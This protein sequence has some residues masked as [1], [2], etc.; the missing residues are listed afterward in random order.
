MAENKSSRTADFI[1]AGAGHNGLI[2]AA[3]LAR[4]GYSVIA[5]DARHIPGGGAATEEPLLPGYRIDSCST[6]HTIIQGNPL[7]TNDELGLK[8]DFR[9]A[10][11][12]PDPVAHVRFPDGEHFTQFLDLEKTLDEIARFSTNDAAA[13]RRMMLE[14]EE[15][16][17]IFGREQF[18]PA[19][20]GESVNRQLAELPSGNI[21]KR[22]RY[23]SAW[24]IIRHEFESKHI[25]SFM[26][27]QAYQ[28]LVRPDATGSG[29]LAYST[30]CARQ[31]R[32]WTIPIG[33]SGRLSEALV[34]SF[35]ANGGEVLINQKVAKLI[36]EEG[37]C[38]GVRTETGDE[39]Y[40]TKGVVSSIHVKHLI[41]MAPTEAWDEAWHYGVGTYDVGTSA[42]AVYLVTTRAPEFVVE[43]GYRTAVSA[44]FVGWPEEVLSSARDFADGVWRDDVQWLLIATPTL[45]DPDRVPVA[46]HHTVK[47]LGPA[48]WRV[49]AGD[50]W[51][52]MKAR[53]RR[54]LLDTVQRWAPEFTDDAVLASLVKGPFDI[55]ASN[56]HMIRG[57]LH[58]G[59]RTL[60]FTGEQ[61]PAPGWANHLTPRKGLYQTGAT[62]HPGGSITGGPGRNAALVILREEGR[63]LAD[64]V[65]SPVGVALRA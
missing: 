11:V 64:V 58:G 14:W 46:G 59:E 49:P 8:A 42:F 19:G 53:R 7:M 21:W 9:L 2:T 13:F 41:D 20:S 25:Q 18:A 38:V 16:K 28:T 47:L 30:V 22:R 1:V 29:L 10:Y 63:D 32:S 27:W 52:S 55:E 57:T 24:D 6:G 45:V 34:A 61:R 33:G 26:L 23:L 36:L 40:G 15:V 39:F 5:L 50:D 44:G 56:P 43:G 37:R 12:D 60:A 4:A 17:A 31:R 35:E 54:L 65:A 62:T 3:Y 48:G 51:D